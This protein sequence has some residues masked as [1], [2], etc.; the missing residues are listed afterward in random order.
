MA[1]G[2]QHSGGRRGRDPS[3]W[4]GWVAEASGENSRV[5]A[6][7]HAEG[8]MAGTPSIS[9]L[10]PP[11][12]QIASNC[13]GLATQFLS[14]GT[15]KSTLIHIKE[16]A[17]AAPMG[18]WKFFTS[19]TGQPGSLVLSTSNTGGITGTLNSTPI[20]AVWDET[21]Q[22]LSFS[23]AT[24][25]GTGPN[26]VGF[27]V[28]VYTGT[29]FQPYATPN[30]LVAGEGV[31]LMLAGNFGTGKIGGTIGPFNQSGWFATNTTKFKEKEGKESKDSKDH[32]DKDKDKEQKD[33][34]EKEGH[35]DKLP[36]FQAMTPGSPGLMA[37]GSEMDGSTSS[38]VRIATGRSFIPEEERPAV[39]S[40]ALQA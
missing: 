24:A 38:E 19:G 37:A 26:D 15:G 14:D 35:P 3:V 33:G 8:R 6:D 22:V 1:T 16:T 39:G 40:T 34:K 18:T 20:T 36:E 25:G 17:M 5:G 29:L 11:L 13:R 7:Q 27:T 4:I 12:D 21:A 32:K 10:T 28:Q 31:P 30:G 9:Q 23:E 2:T